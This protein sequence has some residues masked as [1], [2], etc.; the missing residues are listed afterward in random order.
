MNGEG[1]HY[2]I[3]QN[4]QGATTSYTLTDHKK[5]LGSV[6]KSKGTFQHKKIQARV[7]AVWKARFQLRKRVTLR[8][9]PLRLKRTF[10]SIG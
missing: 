8:Q 6:T 5:S 3:R 7:I 9:I 4:Q 1:S 10:P 2:G